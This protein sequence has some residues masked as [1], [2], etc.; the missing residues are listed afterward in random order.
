MG[1]WLSI[2]IMCFFCSGLFILEQAQAATISVAWI[3]TKNDPFYEQLESYTSYILKDQKRPKRAI[4]SALTEAKTRARASG[5]KLSFKALEVKDL[6]AINDELN[7]FDLDQELVILDLPYDSF[8]DAIK[9]LAKKQVTV[10]NARHRNDELRGVLCQPNM[11]HTIP[12]N[13]MYADALVQ[14]LKF[15]R[16]DE[17]LVLTGPG[18]ENELLRETFELSARRMNLNIK[19]VRDFST[20]KNPAEREKNKISFLTRDA[21]YD[22]VVVF[23]SN[24]DFSRFIPFQTHLPRPVVGDIGLTVRAWHHAAERFGA[25]QLNQRFN[26]PSVLKLASND[27]YPRHMSD[28]DFATWA[29]IK[30]LA[31]NLPKKADISQN[32]NAYEIFNTNKSASVDL[33][34][35]SVGSFRSWDHQLRQ[36]MFITTHNA[37]IHIAPLKGFLHRIN[38]NDTLGVDKPETACSFNK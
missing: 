20:S 12:S 36:P 22:A 2:R 11:F 15:R 13:R 7:A 23:D 31:T 32:I 37:V 6:D 10:I 26:R 33:Y 25:P 19:S 4:L 27:E 28:E 14:W 9:I 8:L 34:K 3:H 16:W 30:F 18:A 17:L 24:A 35:G 5:I 21:R 38:Y 1:S 29:A